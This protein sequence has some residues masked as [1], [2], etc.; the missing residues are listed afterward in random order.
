MNYGVCFVWN[1]MGYTKE[2]YCFANFFTRLVWLI[3]KYNYLEAIPHCLKW[4]IWEEQNARSLDLKLLFFKYLFDSML[5]L[6][7]FFL[8]SLPDLIYLCTLRGWFYCIH[9]IPTRYLGYFYI[10]ISYTHGMPP[11]YLVYFTS[12]NFVIYQINK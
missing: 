10:I 1:S 7:S 8:F 11:M 3:S 6:G 9:S 5:A 2:C 4:C 12:I